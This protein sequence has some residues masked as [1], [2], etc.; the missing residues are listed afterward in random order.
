ML[1]RR[2]F[3]FSPP[4]TPPNYRKLFSLL[5]DW[6]PVG[7]YLLGK[8]VLTMLLFM[9]T[10]GHLLGTPVCVCVYVSVCQCACQPIVAV[11]VKVEG[12]DGLVTFATS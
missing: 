3:L 2:R 5:P 12:C 11:Y 8:K 4:H 10:T 1:N 9:V 6:L 7:A